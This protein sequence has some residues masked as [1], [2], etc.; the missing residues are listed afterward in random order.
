MLLFTTY[1]S[2]FADQ[3]IQVLPEN[4]RATEQR[5]R[6][7]I[8]EK[9]D[10][11]PFEKRAEVIQKAASIL[12]KRPDINISELLENINTHSFSQEAIDKAPFN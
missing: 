1:A 4:R 3:L 12:K 8:Q 7:F 6:D 9:L 2:N 10:R 11:I 5:E